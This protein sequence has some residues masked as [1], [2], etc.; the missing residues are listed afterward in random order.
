MV[1]SSHVLLVPHHLVPTELP[2]WHHLDL[3]TLLSHFVILFCY[4]ILLS[5]FVILFR[6]LILLSYFVI[7]FCDLIDHRD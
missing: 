2:T 7:L 6:Y 5:Y 3:H 4:L 1:R